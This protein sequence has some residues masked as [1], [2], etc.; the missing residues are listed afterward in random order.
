MAC[1]SK[2]LL[3]KQQSFSDNQFCCLF[4][5]VISPVIVVRDGSTNNSTTSKKLCPKKFK[6]F[7]V[8]FD[9]TC[10]N[11]RSAYPNWTKSR[12]DLKFWGRYIS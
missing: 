4:G 12:L 7:S 5:E 2:A 11:W 3:I 1:L 10:Q 6:V 8:S 9:K